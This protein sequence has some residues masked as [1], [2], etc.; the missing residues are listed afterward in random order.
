ML[1][2]STEWTLTRTVMSSAEHTYTHS[3]EETHE[4]WR[5]KE[6]T[7][8]SAVAC[9]CGTAADRGGSSSGGRLTATK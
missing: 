6:D 9:Q 1:R 2:R 7:I 5:A 3:R 8:V 4:S